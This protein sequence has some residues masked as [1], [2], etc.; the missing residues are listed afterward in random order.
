MYNKSLLLRQI[1]LY[2]ADLT[3]CKRKLRPKRRPWSV[4]PAGA[5]TGVGTNVQ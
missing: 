1:S 3:Y 2:T 4:V 5:W